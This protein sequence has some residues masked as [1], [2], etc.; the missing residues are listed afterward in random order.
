M[1]AGRGGDGAV[2]F[3]REKYVPRGGPDGGD[4]GKGGD[5]YVTASN[6]LSTLLDFRYKKIYKAPN[7]QRGGKN[8]KTGE[9]GRSI[10]IKL[11]VGTIIAD[12]ITGHV[13]ADLAENEM[14][15]LIAKGGKGGKGNTRFKS[16]TDQ[17]PRR[18]EEGRSGERMKITL[19]LKSIADV[20]LVGFPNVGKSTLLS[21]LSAAH[22]KIADYPF[23]TRVPNLG[24]VPLKGYRSFVMA[25]IPGLIEGAHKGK[26]MGTQFLRHI[27]RTKMLVY[28]LDITSPEPVKDLEILRQ[29]MESF[30]K[31][32]VKKP[33]ITTFNKIDLV[34]ERPIRVDGFNSGHNSICYISAITGENI[35]LFLESLS[36]ILFQD[37]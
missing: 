32:L 25:D 7:G 29:E 19:E 15:V 35:E 5:I 23:T 16:P 17:T 37:V 28:L 30:D 12:S 8:N 36:G 1:I 13:L 33:S 27:Q 18:A 21:R 6:N 14:E 20:G 31:L 2:S 24:I 11:P 26:G 34:S 4:G 3:H 10:Y 22:P 9:S